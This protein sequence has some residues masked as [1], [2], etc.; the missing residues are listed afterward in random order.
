MEEYRGVTLLPTAY[1][2]FAAILT[3]RIR[4]EIENKGIVPQNQAGF[5]KGMGA[6]DKVYILNYMVNRQLSKKGG[7]LIAL[8]VDLKAAFDKVD[9]GILV[10]TMRKRGIREGL[11]ERVARVLEETR[12]RIRVGKEVGESFWTVRGVRQGCP[13]SPLL[14]NVLLADLEEEIEKGRWGGSKI[15]REKGIYAI[16]RG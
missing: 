15:E 14:F 8:F 1:K 3:E 16:V 9:R 7:K 13:L 2:V 6:L 11:V 5:R 12:S 4:E 10:G